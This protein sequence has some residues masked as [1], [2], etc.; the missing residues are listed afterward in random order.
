MRRWLSIPA[1]SVALAAVGLAALLAIAAFSHGLAATIANSPP[2]V[3]KLA[4]LRIVIV[5]PVGGLAAA[6]VG[7]VVSQIQRRW[8]PASFCL[9]AGAALI[10]SAV[11]LAAL[12][13]GV[14]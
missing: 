11:V 6:T 12:F 4:V 7:C 10:M 2:S 14:E 3:L 9:A 5:L 1:Q 8:L 13:S